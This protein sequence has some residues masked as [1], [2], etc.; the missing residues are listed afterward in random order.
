MKRF[1]FIA[2]AAAA[3]AIPAS[4]MAASTG[5]GVVLSA[6]SHSVQVVNAGHVVSAYSVRG[7]TSRLRTGSEISYRL[8]G[9]SIS[10][11]RVLGSTRTLSYYAHVVRNNAGQLVL[12]LGD[13]K[14]VSFK[15]TQVKVSKHHESH[16]VPAHA[17][18]GF[19]LVV[20]APP[21]TSVLV[22]ES[23]GT[24]ANISVTITI[25]ANGAGNGGGNG[26]GSGDATASG[27]VTDVQLASFGI[28][29][30]Q[31]G[32]TTR[33]AME[34]DSLA[35]INMSPCD[36]VTVSYRQDLSGLVA[37]K[38]DDSGTSDGGAC[39]DN[40]TYYPTQD[41][42]GSITDMTPSSITISTDEGPM[43]FP[44]LPSADLLDGF[45]YG[46]DVDVTYAQDPDGM[47]YV[48]DVEYAQ[49]YASGVVESVSDNQLTILDHSTQQPDV[50][51]L[52]P[53]DAGEFDGI[54]SGDEVQVTWH[55]AA[56]GVDVADNV[57][58]LGPASSAGP[59]DPG[60]PG[61]RRG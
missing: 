11:V 14:T 17:A 59:G 8:S 51:S 36:T 25:E 24:G 38:V 60:Y 57:D 52:G 31:T 48:V 20:N 47:L 30:E 53:G 28:V 61:N 45:Q 1:A 16:A 37:D 43:T 29:D 39:D 34:P 35:A 6:Q 18:S 55:Q 44:V 2:T 13:G 5:S 3:L 22:T 19:T 49:S 42:V 32:A 4:S 40:G 58:D 33:F 23:I 15:P 50:F 21:G 26:G 27:T 56:N 7:S 46:D 54:A 9:H 10:A 12:S 41:A